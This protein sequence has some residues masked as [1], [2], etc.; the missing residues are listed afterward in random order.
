MKAHAEHA[1]NMTRMTLSNGYVTLL[2]DEDYERF[3][4]WKWY[5][6]PTHSKVYVRR[7]YTRNQ[8]SFSEMLHRV[9]MNAPHGFQ[10]DHIDGDTLN[11][12][13]SNLRLCTPTENQRYKRSMISK[14]RPAH[15][16]FKGVRLTPAGRYKA[17]IVHERQWI[18]LGT[19]DSAMDAARAYDTKAIELRGAFA[20][21]NFPSYHQ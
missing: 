14:P 13:K 16:P 8:K 10:V 18:Y 20:C 19:Y 4:Q 7:G 12:Q 5:G 3:K 15:R 17:S 11:N 21:T 9:I 1:P 2:D 6:A